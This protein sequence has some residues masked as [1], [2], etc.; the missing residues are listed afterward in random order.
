MKFQELKQEPQRQAS[1]IEYKRWKKES[2]TLKIEQ[3]KWMHWSKKMLNPKKNG[4][5]KPPEN[6]KHYK[7][8]KNNGD[9]GR[10]RNPD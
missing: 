8:T 3:T 4:G 7:N 9:R 1:P 2:Q 10:Q 6:L 5:T